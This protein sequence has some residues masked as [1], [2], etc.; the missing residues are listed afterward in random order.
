MLDEA[1]ETG[2]EDELP[3]NSLQGPAV[4]KPRDLWILGPHRLLCG[5][6]DPL[7]CDV[8]VRR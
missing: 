2:P 4:S 6:L 1:A 5:E 8:I 7:S 3:A